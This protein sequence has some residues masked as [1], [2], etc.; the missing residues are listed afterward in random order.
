L[1]HL[2][3]VSAGVPEIQDWRIALKTYIGQIVL[4]VKSEMK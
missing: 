2:K 4:A 1:G 3:T